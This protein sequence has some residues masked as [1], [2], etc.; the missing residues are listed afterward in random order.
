MKV[1]ILHDQALMHL[2]KGRTQTDSIRVRTGEN[3]EFD[4]L[5]ICVVEDRFLNKRVSGPSR[6]I[7][8]LADELS[9]LGNAV[10]VICAEQNPQNRAATSMENRH[11]KIIPRKMFGGGFLTAI[12]AA[13]KLISRE[14]PDVIHSQ[15]YRNL[16][17]DL[18]AVA[19]FI[20]RIP[21]VVTPRGSLLGQ[22]HR[23]SDSLMGV[24]CR[25]YDTLTLK[26]SLRVASAV[27]VTSQQEFN[28]GLRLG[29][30]K[31]KLRLIPH[32]MKMPD[33]PPRKDKL[34]GDP[35]MLTVSRI[36]PHRNI[37]TIIEAFKIV[38]K[39]FPEAVLYIAGD[40]IP[41]S[42]DSTERRYPSL[43]RDL[44]ETENLDGKVKL[45]GGVYGD[46]LWRLYVSS[47]L[48]IYASS[49]DNFGFAL[50]EA[51]ALG[52]PIVSTRAGIAE[53]LIQ[54][55][56]GGVLVNDSKPVSVAS[57]IHHMLTLPLSERK[58]MG[59]HLKERAK[60]YSIEENAKKHME[61]YR[62]LVNRRNAT[63]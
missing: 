30:P 21:F 54:D 60:H 14:K 17:T 10:T 61:L 15:G 8:Y 20:N 1:G 18:C 9:S 32:G 59:E 5:V 47:D 48:F 42:H 45:L 31:R 41:S 50:L 57:A 33:P 37:T 27:V 12:P 49:Y 39:D 11:F 53:D 52:L 51:A 26:M 36:T 4:Q 2:R 43:V 22:T 34:E 24:A 38:L 56:R 19:A 63:N 16:T 25:V 40:A 55:D 58:A 62:E 28:E 13:M 23:N 46:G 7:G 6:H 35:K 3:Q 44:I 29:V